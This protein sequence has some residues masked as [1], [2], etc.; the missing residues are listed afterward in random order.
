MCKKSH[1]L[2]SR[3]MEGGEFLLVAKKQKLNILL[4]FQTNTFKGISRQSME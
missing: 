2:N 1:K 4:D 3:K